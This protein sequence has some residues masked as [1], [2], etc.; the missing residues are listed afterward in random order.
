M[1]FLKDPKMLLLGGI[2]VIVVYLLMK[3]KGSTTSTSTTSD[4][5]S[6]TPVG[7]SYSYLDGS[8]YQ[9]ITATDPNGN[10]VSYSSLP[11]D[12]SNPQP[13]QLSTY[14]G[15]MSNQVPYPYGGVTPPWAL[16]PYYNYSQN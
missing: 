16:S 15:S 9:H 8:G 7:Q 3:N 6:T 5:N 11:P 10:L 1:D 13:N 4:S 12:L 14:A 2:G